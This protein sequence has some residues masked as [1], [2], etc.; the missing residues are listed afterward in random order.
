MNT[1]RARD[2]ASLVLPRSAKLRP[3]LLRVR[4]TVDGTLRADGFVRLAR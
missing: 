2:G 1:L 4:V 3:G